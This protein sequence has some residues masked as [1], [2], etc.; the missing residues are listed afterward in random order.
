MLRQKRPVL[1]IVGP[2]ATGKSELGVWIAKQIG[3]EVLSAD[4]MQ[5][6]RQ[7]DIGTAK[8]T[9]QEM[10]GVPHHLMDLVEPNQPFTVADW[11]SLARE[12]IDELHEAG[13]LPIVVGGTGLYVRSITDDLDFAEQAGSVECR[14]RWQMFAAQKGNK[15][16]HL[17][18]TTRDPEAAS[19]LHPNDLRR[20]I[21]ALEVYEL[22][23]K[24]LS[25]SYD[26]TVK[27]GRYET[28]Q[29]A[30]TMERQDLYDRVEQR[31][32]EMMRRGLY[33]EVEALLS[34]GYSHSLT[35]MQA[36]GYKELAACIEGELS[37]EDAV[38]QVKQA[39]RRF[40]KRQLSW[41]RRDPRVV[42]YT[43]AGQGN[44]PVLTFDTILS[45]VLTLV[46]GIPGQGLE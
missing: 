24:P 11:S 46:A 35:S 32:D 8:L 10:A 16:L 25:A 15:A 39:T 19:R 21:R 20:V 2:T 6:Y 45:S 33:E 44:L 26:W 27:A 14:E 9:A 4:S 36:I 1:C 37:C 12:K 13:K 5:V 23:L 29:V 42:W 31:V 18:L 41:F 34:R 30:L 38:L 17:E 7:M 28:L 22:G 40:V 43:R 3:G